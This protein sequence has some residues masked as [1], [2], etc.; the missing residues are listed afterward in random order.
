ML[1]GTPT[2]KLRE[3]V[4]DGARIG[5]EDVR[6]VTVDQDPGIV[7]AVLGIAAAMRPAVD[8]ED[9]FSALRGDPLCKNASG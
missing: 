1:V 3:I 4:D 6:S 8:D 7:E 5:V 2:G 9:G